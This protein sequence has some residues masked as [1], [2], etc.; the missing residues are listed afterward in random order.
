MGDTGS[1]TGVEI[2]DDGTHSA[3]VAHVLSELATVTP[4]KPRLEDITTFPGNGA[5]GSVVGVATCSDPNDPEL[6]ASCLSGLEHLIFGSCS[7]RA[8][9]Y[10]GNDSDACTMG[11]ATP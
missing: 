10:V 4:T 7:S 2:S 11:F 6:C 1:C 8:G 3:Y 9:G 5:S